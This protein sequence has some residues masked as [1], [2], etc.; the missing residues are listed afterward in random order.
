MA[1]N[2]PLKNF[3]NVGIIA[4][5]D[6]GKTT[7]TEGILYRTGINHKIGEVKGDGDGATT[8][9]MAQEKER[10]ITITS[11]AVTC[12]WKGH[13][14]NIIDTP[15]H[16]DFTAEV[17]RSLRV[18]DGAVTVFDGKMGVEA[19][20]E[21]VWRQANKYG[22]P[23]LCFINKIN[24]TG[25]DFYKSLESIH[26]RLSKQAFPIHL[27]IGFEKDVCGVVDLV[28]MKAYT[29]KDY[30]DHELI[31]GEIPADML[32]KAQNARS[33]LVENAVEADDD[34]MMK[35]LD[36]GEESITKDELKMALRKRVL[37]GDFFLVTGGDGRGVIVEKLLDIMTDY[38]P[39]PLDVDEIWG[40]NPKTGD[41]VGRKPDNKEPM[42]ALAFKIAADPFVGKLIFVRV[43]SG[44]LKAGS[45]V[46][47]T[48]T[49]EKER[50][51]RIVRM[52]A[53]KREDIDSVG[54]G[55]IAAVV[56]LKNTYTG[57]TLADAAH[58]IA[59]ES[60]EFPDPPVSIAVE[61]KTKADQEK[62]GIALQ[63]LAEEDP[64]FRIHTDEDTG[65]TI[66]SGMGELHLEILIDRMK[67]EF[68][69][70]ANVGEP[71]VAY[72]ETIKG[73]A[74]VQ[75]KHAK[76]SGGR[77]QYGDVWVRFE[78]NETGKGFEFIDEIK[79][80]VVPQEYR[81]AVQKG[82][83]ETL[84]GGVIAGYPV[85]D[86]KATLYDGSYH[87]VDSSELAFSLAGSLA[88][89]AGIKQANP[90]L[91]EPV[92]HVEVTTPEEFMGD[93]IGDLNSRR[94]RIEA[95]EDLMGGA[96]LIKAIVP[97][98]N[99]FGY[100]SDIRSMSQG[101]AASTMELAHYEEV[102]PNVAQEIIEKRSK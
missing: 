96:K 70:E 98:A 72:R 90:V 61:P 86:V 8:D 33:L 2:V 57:N 36:E 28:E 49:G 19:Q 92:M 3:R 74:E 65:Q 29:Y 10:G 26:T 54:A 12:F 41:E 43:Y 91:L 73:T 30:T 60:I 76:Q 47:N 83:V 82:I 20:S 22:V 68:N 45:Y 69:V 23:R 31:E 18:L 11:A 66:M 44:V 59:L 39:S 4:H 25:G 7:T 1:T 50:I 32:E 56:G 13:K 80:G 97:L 46:L 53:D 84:N 14:I 27:P 87:D 77:G 40:K 81:P 52:H 5:I 89:R 55:D 100:T 37:A 34:L 38:L 93:I 17:E 9:W 6:A 64:T 63:R 24:Q 35:F 78:P 99:M 58:P 71:Q 48:T 42:A 62:M 101:R 79:G 15:G 88:A 51:G 95:M 21:T 16:I 67:R 75:G 85:V 94:G 102:P